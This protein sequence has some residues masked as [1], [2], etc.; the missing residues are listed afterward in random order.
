MK[1]TF[2]SIKESKILSSNGPWSLKNMETVLKNVIMMKKAF[3]KPK[4]K[5]LACS[6]D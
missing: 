2:F 3:G 4:G 1:N 6:A 5:E